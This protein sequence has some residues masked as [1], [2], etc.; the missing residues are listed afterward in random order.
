MLQKQNTN[1]SVKENVIQYKH[2][3]ER[4]YHS[5]QTHWCKEISLSTNKL[6]Q[7]NIIFYK[8]IGERKYHL[9]LKMLNMQGVT[10]NST[11]VSY[12]HP[13]KQIEIQ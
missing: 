10:Q 12:N 13:C 5:I 2:T 7:R 9:K 3:C 6:M 1:I 11:S 4:K 8:H